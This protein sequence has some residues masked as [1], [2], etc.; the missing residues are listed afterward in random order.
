M[1]RGGRRHRKSNAEHFLSG[2]FRRDRHATGDVPPALS[3]MAPPPP[4]E[5]L[6]AAEREAWVEL[7]AEVRAAQTYNASRLSAFR[8]AVKALALAYDPPPTAKPATVRGLLENASK[9][10]GRFGLD[11]ISTL[12]VEAPPRDPERDG[13]GDDGTPL[14][15]GAHDPLREFTPSLRTFGLRQGNA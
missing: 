12:Q 9:L 10:I 14:I 5:G 13:L 15:G 7:A 6:S 2:T 1:P 4:P 3:P 8:L 11:A